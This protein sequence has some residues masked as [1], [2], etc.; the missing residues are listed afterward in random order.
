MAG[1]P[2][3]KKREAIRHCLDNAVEQVS[4]WIDALRISMV[5]RVYPGTELDKAIKIISKVLDTP[6]SAL[7]CISHLNSAMKL[8]HSYLSANGLPLRLQ[9]IIPR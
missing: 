7:D 8:L 9:G 5:S 2:I 3:P 6:E 4:L 1:R